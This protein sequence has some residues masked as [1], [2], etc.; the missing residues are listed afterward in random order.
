MHQYYLLYFVV[1]IFLSFT[2]LA[3]S[4]TLDIG[5]D[6]IVCNFS[7]TVIDA[8]PGFQ[9]YS[10]SNGITTQSIN[11]FSTQTVGVTVT[12]FDGNTQA[13]QK[14]VYKSFPPIVDF[15]FANNCTGVAVAFIDNSTT[16]FDALVNWH[17]DFGDGDTS[18]EINPVHVFTTAGLF[19]VSL[20]VT[21]AVGCDS[22][23][24]KQVEIYPL[25]SVNAGNDVFTNINQPVIINATAA[26]GNY[27]W[28]PSVFLNNNDVLDPT[29]LPATNVTYI[30]TVTDT[31]GCINS[32]TVSVFVNLPPIAINKNGSIN[33][34]TSISFYSDQI[35]T[36][37]NNDILSFTIVEPPKN[38]TAIIQGDTIIYIPNE[39]FSGSD[40]ITFQVCD[41][42]APPLC[43]QGII[44]INVGNIKPIA[45]ND[46]IETEIATSV[47]FNVFENDIEY[48]EQQKIEINF[49]SIPE[50]GNVVDLNNG[51][52][53][54]TPDFGFL[55]VDSFYYEICDNGQPILCDTAWVYVTVKNIPIF[56][57][58]SFSPNSDGIFDNFIIEGILSFPESKLVIFNRWGEIVFEAIGY[59]NNFDGFTGFKEELPSATY[60]YH[61]DL[62][63]GSKPLTGYL[64]L[65]R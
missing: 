35:A 48:N 2:Q 16:F 8:G 6:T 15:E 40:T 51:N 53:L 60:F 45:N 20:T 24:T 57:N 52:L 18:N 25:P 10:W 1:L 54:Y 13:A 27:L 11:V 59:K 39:N 44:V 9:F 14:I 5:N 36:D 65:K 12:D 21:N 4:Q 31:L 43:S 47:N 34:N 62:K 26:A 61:L 41:A 22:T 3:K 19:N 49:V 29:C 58:N 46:S 38:G 30:L 37:A 56:I 7:A 55:G 32:D 42:G 28:S 50:N 33:A 23:I 64:I 17:W 63:D